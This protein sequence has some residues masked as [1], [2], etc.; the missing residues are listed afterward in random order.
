MFEPC[1]AYALGKGKKARV[2]KMAVQH[3]MVKE[4][5][6]FMDISSSYAANL[7]GKKH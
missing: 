2:N 1:K 5:S 3:S 7:G 6:Q 4:E